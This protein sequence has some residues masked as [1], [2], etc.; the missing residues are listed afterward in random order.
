MSDIDALLDTYLAA[1]G[2]AL[3]VITTGDK[4]IEE[5]KELVAAIAV[6]D[7]PAIR[8]ELAD[9]VIVAAVVARQWGTTVEA[10]ILE[11]A[12]SDKGRGEGRSLREDEAA[13]FAALETARREL[14]PAV[15]GELAELGREA[16]E[17][18][19]AGL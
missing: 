16:A 5:A 6:G 10:C 11:K 13:V 3:P 19:S 9:L 1:R 2:L 18:P 8:A 4:A 15:L 17:D 14:P 7:D 12:A